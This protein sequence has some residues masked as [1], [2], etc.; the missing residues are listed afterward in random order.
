M[1]AA[2]INYVIFY[3]AVHLCWLRDYGCADVVCILLWRHPLVLSL[4]ASSKP[5]DLQEIV[6]MFEYLITRC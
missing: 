4:T 2:N 6:G 3:V 1:I 5:L